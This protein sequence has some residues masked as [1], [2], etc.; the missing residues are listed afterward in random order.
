MARLPTP[1]GDDGDWG[2]ILN[3]FL[4]V[5]H[6]ADGSLGGNTVDSAQLKDSSVTDAK[7]NSNAAIS[8]SKLSSSVQSSLDKADGALQ[9]PG[10][11]VD[12]KIV[13][14]DQTSGTLQD[15]TSTLNNAYL[16]TSTPQVLAYSQTSLAK[17]NLGLTINQDLGLAAGIGLSAFEDFSTHPNGYTPLN[18]ISPAGQRYISVFTGDHA[19]VEDGA[20]VNSVT[21]GYGGDGSNGV[22]GSFAVAIPTNTVPTDLICEFSFDDRGGTTTTQA[23]NVVLACG[24]GPLVPAL[25]FAVTPTNWHPFCPH[26]VDGT[27]LVYSDLGGFSFVDLPETLKTDGTRYRMR[28]HWHGDSGGDP[29]TV[30]FFFPGGQQDITDP[31]IGEFWGNVV[32]CQG[33]RQNST[34]G[35][36]R[37]HSFAVGPGARY[38][39]SK[40]ASKAGSQ[41]GL[42]F[43]GDG[44]SM[45]S[46]EPFAHNYSGDLDIIALIAPDTYAPTKIQY[47]AGSY[48]VNGNRKAWLA[49]INS[50]GRLGITTSPDGSSIVTDSCSTSVPGK[51]GV[52]I[53]VRITRQADDGSGNRVTQFFT[54]TDFD[55]TDI[56]AETWTQLG[57]TKTVADTNPGIHSDP[58]GIPFTVGAGN[59]GNSGPFTG[60]VLFLL[61]RDGIDGN[62]IC[63]LDDTEPWSEYFDTPGSYVDPEG[64]TWFA[65]GSTQRSL[66]WEQI[67]LPGATSQPSLPAVGEPKLYF[68]GDVTN[69]IQTGAPDGYVPGASGKIVIKA[70]INPDNWHG[71]NG[72]AQAIGGIWDNVNV[73]RAY[74]LNLQTNAHLQLATSYDGASTNTFYGSNA[75]VPED[76]PY[77]KAALDI[78]SPAAGQNTVTFYTSSDGVTYTQLGDAVTATP[79]GGT[80]IFASTGPI[81]VGARGSSSAQSSTIPFK[82]YIPH[83]AV[84]DGTNEI[85]SLD[86]T[87]V[88]FGYQGTP[89]YF[90]DPEGNVWGTNDDSFVW[91]FSIPAAAT[92]HRT[93]YTAS[94]SVTIPTG[95]MVRVLAR[96]GGGSGGSGGSDALTSP[97]GGQA[98]G[99][100]GAAGCVAS[101]DYTSDGTALN[102]TIGGGGTSRAGGAASTGATGNAGLVGNAGGDTTVSGGGLGITL[103]ASGGGGGQA[104]SDKSATNAGGGLSGLVGI[105]SSHA[106]TGFPGCGC[107]STDAGMVGRCCPPWPGGASGG[108]G[109]QAATA[110]KGGLG[111]NAGLDGSEWPNVPAGVGGMAGL[112]GGAGTAAAANSSAGGGGGGGGAPGGKGGDSGAGGSG[113]VIVEAYY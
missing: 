59:T 39:P 111:G 102:F 97:N 93:V 69:Y 18:Q 52:P 107:Y 103:V 63:R 92:W 90:T 47:F 32:T 106:N 11:S 56:G 50:S 48:L 61:V 67:D 65:T 83:F 24:T 43:P 4:G 40:P 20:L 78:D 87:S 74:S 108:A 17:Q 113:S 49:S 105:Y 30:T 9:A 35:Y 81:Q 62:E 2:D 53:P 66:S 99:G 77:I 101:R 55:P 10:P 80:S 38:A 5:S 3:N 54:S 27:G 72:Y 91:S 73:A 68:A 71:N 37:I 46:T 109:G 42:H 31:L 89:G 15:A 8:K 104:S 19:V 23:N 13:K 6:A 98:G 44:T 86:N 70:E 57:N 79:A 14:W 58:D 112:D 85:A 95:A 28:L 100:G 51:A 29:N 41:W 45:V 7:I 1:G 22:N 84:T 64:H 88:W 12:G 96:G 110:T 82:G 16:S 60:S 34:D 21:D 33:R 25:Q 94:G 76:Q 26:S 75:A 36:N